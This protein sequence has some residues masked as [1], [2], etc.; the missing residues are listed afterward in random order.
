[1]PLLNFCFSGFVIYFGYGI[2]HSS[3]GTLVRTSSDEVP[4]PLKPT[5]AHNGDA[6]LH[7]KEAFLSAGREDG[8][9]DDGE[10]W[11][12]ER[13]RRASVPSTAEG[14]ETQAVYQAE[15]GTTVVLSLPNEGVLLAGSKLEMAPYCSSFF[16]I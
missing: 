6:T 5:C 3:E 2:W 9:D 10:L 16:P 12:T 4:D 7:E 14:T 11:E 13:A 8:M 1:M 15:C